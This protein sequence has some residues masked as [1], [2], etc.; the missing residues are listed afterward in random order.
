MRYNIK[1]VKYDL[2][3]ILIIG[4]CLRIISLILVKLSPDSYGY[5]D[6]AEGILNLSYNTHRPPTFSLIIMFF[7]II[8]RDS[9]LAVKLA[10]FFIGVLLIIVSYFVFSKTALQIFKDDEKHL[11]KS[12]YIGILSSLYISVHGFIVWSS[13][14]GIREDLIS[15]LYIL[16]YYYICVKPDFHS[17]ENYLILIIITSALTLSHVSAGIF[18]TI[19]FLLI[20]LFSKLKLIKIN[21]SGIKVLSITISF[22]F[23]YSFWLIFC[24]F[25]FGDPFYT[26]TRQNAWFEENTSLDLGSFSGI[27]Q[28][29]F[30]GITLGVLI[31]FIGI[32]Q[33]IGFV[34]TIVM[35]IFLIKNLK[36][37]QIFL[38]FS[39]IFVNFSYLCIFIAASGNIRLLSYFLPFLFFLGITSLIK[40]YYEKRELIIKSFSIFKKK[41]VFSLHTIFYFYIIS[42]YLWNLFL[43]LNLLIFD[44]RLLQ[45]SNILDFLG[46]FS[47]IMYVTFFLFQ[48]LFLISILILPKFLQSKKSK[49]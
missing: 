9:I 19:V 24:T 29:M 16:L 39:I 14:R 37:K 38:L 34:F 48:E 42:L 31:E 3:L 21:I 5:I 32:F 41:F 1:N 46:P 15:L 25:N 28:N 12:S 23:S 11:E 36:N 18:V 22:V 27:L 33:F 10:S 8:V 7:I 20:Y 13:G 2:L 26:I 6:G 49:F 47:I 44:F 30:K 17:W 40:Y 4:A 43:Y 45:N 35:I